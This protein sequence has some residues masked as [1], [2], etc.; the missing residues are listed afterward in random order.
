MLSTIWDGWV[1]YLEPET[2]F[3]VPASLVPTIAEMEGEELNPYESPTP[4]VEYEDM[5]ARYP[6]GK[7][8]EGRAEESAWAGLTLCLGSLAEIVGGKR[9]S[10]QENLYGKDNKIAER[11]YSFQFIPGDTGYQEGRL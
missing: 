1:H 11:K 6:D 9:K 5:P 8:P 4:I 3:A 2:D 10:Y 7:E